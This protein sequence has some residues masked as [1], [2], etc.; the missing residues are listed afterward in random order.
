M[1]DFHDLYQQYSDDI[2]RFAL[3]LCGNAADA[4]DITAETFTRV[5]TGKTV[6][7]ASS[8]KGYLLTIARNL[9]IESKRR[10]SRMTE[11]PVDLVD[12]H[13]SIEKAY[14][15][16]Q[17]LSALLVYLQSLAETD[18]AALLF[19]VDGLSY[20]DT[21]NALDIS[22]AAAKVSVHRTRL[23]LAKWQMNQE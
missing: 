11:L 9:Y 18:R 1:T 23:K 10:Q 14:A 17:K 2:F 5:I 12:K 6:L 7:R 20:S 19:R 13:P 16:Q 3:F 15:D 21:A 4:E 8:V 22:L